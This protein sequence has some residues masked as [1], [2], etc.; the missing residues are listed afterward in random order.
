MK[1]FTI[2]L[3]LFLMVGAMKL[4]AQPPFRP[5]IAAE[6]FEMQLERGDTVKVQKG[7]ITAAAAQRMSQD[8]KADKR[9]SRVARNNGDEDATSIWFSLDVLENFIKTIRDSTRNAD[10]QLNLGVR[11]YYAK[12]PSA[13]EMT[14]AS[15]TGLNPVVAK[16]HTVFLVPTYY[17]D[18]LHMNADF[19][20]DHIGN[21]CKPTLYYKVMENP[22][23][24]PI[25]VLGALNS[26]RAPNSGTHVFYSVQNHGGLSPPNGAGT[27]PTPP[28]PQ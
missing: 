4:T 5:P 16:H 26:F 14:A 20:F 23:T 9:K 15:F 8:Y 13:Q 22:T 12:Y 25:S 11:I 10:C 19:S 27:F 28:K 24:K 1:R 2:L 21:K 17:S 6:V 7:F 3:C 18:S